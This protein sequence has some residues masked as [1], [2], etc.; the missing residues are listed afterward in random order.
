MTET[1][2]SDVDDL[3]RHLDALAAFV[4]GT[5]GGELRDAATYLRRYAEHLRVV[6]LADRYIADLTRWAEA[7]DRDE[8][9][10]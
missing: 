10:P 8:H 3:A 7:H 1:D 2:P 9:T 5:I 4:G 6:E